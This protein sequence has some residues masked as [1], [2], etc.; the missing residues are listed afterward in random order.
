MPVVGDP[1]NEAAAMDC[2]NEGRCP[3][4]LFLS[5]RISLFHSALKIRASFSVHNLGCKLALYYINDPKSGS[6]IYL[7][8]ISLGF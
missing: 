5:L 7:K 8:Q 3:D 6:I 4:V 1:V 2:W